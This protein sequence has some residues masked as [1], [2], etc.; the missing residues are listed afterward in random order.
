MSK[1]AA[2][3]ATNAQHRLIGIDEITEKGSA[4]ATLTGAV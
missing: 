2:E 3:I 4:G 1:M